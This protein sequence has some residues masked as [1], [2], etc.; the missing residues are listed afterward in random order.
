[1]FSFFGNQNRDES[2]GTEGRLRSVEWKI[3]VLLALVGVHLL[4][5][6]LSLASSVFLPSKSTILIVLI[7]LA[8]VGWFLRDRILVMIRRSIAQRIL[9]EEPVDSSTSSQSS[10][11]GSIR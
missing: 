6:L 11:E 4:L 8:V 5:E 1:M 9:G 3:N 2:T 10:R 7:L